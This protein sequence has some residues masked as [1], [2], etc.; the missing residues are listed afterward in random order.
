M[1]LTF[2]DGSFKEYMLTYDKLKMQNKELEI[3]VYHNE[4]EKFQSFMDSRREARQNQ[5]KG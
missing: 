1:K 2:S 3:G 4:D 5:S